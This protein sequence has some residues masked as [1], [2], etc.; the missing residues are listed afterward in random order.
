[1]LGYTLWQ[2]RRRAGRALTLWLGIFVA[3]VS[4]V[5]LTGTT[6][7]SALHVRGT[8]QGSFRSAYDVLV[9]PRGTT[10]PL[11]RDEGLVRANFLS[12]IYGGITLRQYREIK[13]LP[14]VEVAAPIANI[15]TILPQGFVWVPLQRLL[16]RER[17][18][19]YKV[20]FSW[21]SNGGLSRYPG[22]TEY[23]YYT[24]NPLVEYPP[25]AQNSFIDE[26][27]PGRTPLP[28]CTGFNESAPATS[29][30]FAASPTL[31]CA[32]P[33]IPAEIDREL[34]PHFFRPF[35]GWQLEFPI[36]L[37]AIDPQ[38]EARLLHLDRT[39]IAGRYLHELEGLQK[40]Q[41]KRLVPVLAST[42]AYLG[43]RLLA[44]ISRLRPPHGVD[45]PRLLATGSCTVA[46]VP[47]PPGSTVAPPP[48]AAKGTT[49]YRF[50][51]S[52]P[53]TPIASRSFSATAAYQAVLGGGGNLVVQAYWT[54]R[55]AR[56]RRLGPDRLA[57]L[58]TTNPRSI[59]RL[60]MGTFF[61]AP[62]QNE[63]VQF[64]RL[65]ETLGNNRT[66]LQ[67]RLLSPSLEI[68]GR[69]DPTRLPGFSPLSRV[70][71]ETYYP[72]LL[73]PA[74][75]ASARALHGRA[76]L[77][78]QNIGGYIQ[79]PPLFLTT[80]QGLKAFLDRNAF[81]GVTPRM[82]RAPISAIRIRVHGVSGANA[83]SYARIRTVAQEIHDSTGL[84]VDITAGSSPHPVRIALPAGRFGQPPLLLREGW[85]K[86]GVSIAFLRA[87]DHK[88]AALFALVL[89]VCGL[90]LTN[91]ALASVRARRAE[92]GTLLTLGWSRQAI[93][94]IV[95]GELALVGLAAGIAG[96][97]LAALLVAGLQLRF[98]LAATAY[99]LPL[100][101]GLAL[102]AGLVPAWRAASGEPLD[103]I[104]PA[105][106][107]RRR[108]RR[109]RRLAG[110]ALANLRRLP[111]RTAL[112]AAGL[113]LGAAALTVLVAIQ[114]GFQ[115]PLVGTL[116]GH[117]ISVQVRA[118]DYWAVALTVALAALS[119]ADVIYLNLRER[120]GELAALRST[121]WRDR[122]LARLVALEAL[123]LG[124]LGGG[125][126]ALAGFAI[127]AGLLA[128]P[129]EASALAALIAAAGATAAALAAS[130]LPLLRL[131]GA[132]PHELL[133]SE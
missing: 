69:F 119:V 128:A 66:D 15:G 55:S 97:G 124:L 30:P 103:A 104:Q 62:A 67:G 59:W 84:T 92:I 53:S 108:S 122:H 105:V 54:A 90:F 117:A 95:L 63:D 44:S 71:L 58:E 43:D 76:Y 83:L 110:L 31:T 19:L 99:V 64:R 88:D 68:V 26:A 11:E 20:T 85:S 22:W 56:Y 40:T 49:A 60:N 27:V 96:T 80:L 4:F 14:G 77:P 81:T 73:Q 61:Q 50:V 2:V 37:A 112:A 41:V 79:Q 29:G 109:V 9:R 10:T 72:P 36:A 100:A 51:S 32:S 23:V 28:V 38:Q 87:L 48:N 125:V 25:G 8:L 17:H 132:T 133:T 70:P 131:N 114:R 5:L 121:G 7:T 82:R 12:G 1:V 46:R 127:A 52:L 42:R 107:G 74:D 94:R 24:R 116:L 57:P 78:T 106:S 75:T 130:A 89:V 33:R 65:H 35:A 115:G 86:K 21:R 120:A 101:I 39:V 47:C 16:T 45:L 102:V 34:G 91:G 129:L 111:A 13:R 18:Q 113:A 3:A 93:F 98:S 118:V 6:R 123:A 126:G